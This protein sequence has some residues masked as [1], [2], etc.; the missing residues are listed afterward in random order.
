[1]KKMHKPSRKCINQPNAI[2]NMFMMIQNLT[3]KLSPTDLEE[4]KC[5]LLL[6]KVNQCSLKLVEPL[7]LALFHAQ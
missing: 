5:C 1:M 6:W 2:N 3:L 7:F 4:E